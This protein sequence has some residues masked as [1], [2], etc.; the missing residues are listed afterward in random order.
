MM[1]ERLRP[2][3]SGR[4][5]PRRGSRFFARAA[6]PPPGGSTHDGPLDRRENEVVRAT[7]VPK[8]DGQ[9]ED[10][11]RAGRSARRPLREGGLPRARDLGDALL[12]LAGEGAGGRPGGAG[13]QGGA[14][15][16]AGAAPE[17]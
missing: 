4:A 6:A 16:R 13:G 8:L 9:A 5:R 17:D 14:S 3:G 12:L 1:S 11:D 15:R 7:Q 2:V 10:R